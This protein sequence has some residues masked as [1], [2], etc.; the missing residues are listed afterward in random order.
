MQAFLDNAFWDITRRQLAG[1]M[2]EELPE[3]LSHLWNEYNNAYSLYSRVA[4]CSDAVTQHNSITGMCQR[5]S[6]RTERMR[7][8]PPESEEISV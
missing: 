5:I 2:I 8:A 6:E 1:E 4:D 7:Q 3:E